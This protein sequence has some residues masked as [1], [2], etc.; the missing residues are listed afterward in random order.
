ME[1]HVLTEENLHSPG[2]K[3][4]LLS[5]FLMVC[6]KRL[7]ELGKK[8]PFPR[9]PTCLRCSSE[10]VWCHGFKDAYYDGYSSALPQRRYI[11]ADCGCVYTMRPFGYWPRHHCHA[12]VILSSMCLRIRDGSWGMDA[13]L[14]RQRRRHW[15]RA[16]TRN[17]KAHLGMD[18][19]GGSLEG[20]Y[21]LVHRGR[22]PVARSG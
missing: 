1:F 10:R 2:P 20:F 12:V 19:E 9:P 4:D 18:F 17:I 11:C 15:L 5:L 8:Y 21:E 6:I 3:G 16:L 7:F 14:S 13:L 22:I